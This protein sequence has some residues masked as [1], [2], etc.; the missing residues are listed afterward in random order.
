MGGEGVLEVHFAGLEKGG[1]V[2]E[3]GRL[4][5][6]WGERVQ[7]VRVHGEEVVRVDAV[8]AFGW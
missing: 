2:I 6:D 4:R 8:T 3:F 1:G 7:V 5:V